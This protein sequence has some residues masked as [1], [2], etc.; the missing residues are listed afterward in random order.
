MAPNL[1]NLIEFGK[2]VEG[3]IVGEILRYPQV[4]EQIVAYEVF[5]SVAEVLIQT[6]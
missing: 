5:V 4:Q 6:T 2:H 3:I 1:H